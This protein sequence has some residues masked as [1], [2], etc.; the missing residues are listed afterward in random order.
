MGLRFPSL[1]DSAEEIISYQKNV[2]TKFGS[3]RNVQVTEWENYRLYPVHQ[4]LDGGASDDPLNEPFAEPMADSGVAGMPLSQLNRIAPI[5]DGE[6]ARL[7]SSASSPEITPNDKTTRIHRA[8]RLSQHVLE[9]ILD[10]CNWIEIRQQDR[11]NALQY[12]TGII[13]TGIELDFDDLENIPGDVYSCECGWVVAAK[14][15]KEVGEGI[16]EFS[17]ERAEEMAMNGIG[18]VVSPPGDPKVFTRLSACPECS[19]PLKKRVSTEADEGVDAFGD[20]L[21]DEIPNQKAF[22]RCYSVYDFFPAG[23]GRSKHG[24]IPEYTM[25]SIVDIESLIKRHKHADKIKPKT[26]SELAETVRWH[27]S[28][29]EFGGLYGANAWTNGER[30]RWCVYRITVREPFKNDDGEPEPLGRVIIS[31]NDVVLFNGPLMIEHKETKRKIPRYKIHIG[32][33]STEN[34]SCYGAGL[35]QRLIGMQDTVNN[36]ASMMEYNMH[37]FGSPRMHLPPGTTIEYIGTGAGKSQSDVLQWTGEQPP[38]VIQGN[39]QHP[40]ATKLIDLNFTSMERAANQAD[41][42]RGAPPPG[43]SAASAMIY[44]GDQAGAAKK[45][46]EERFADRDAKI[47]RHILEIVNA[48]YDTPRQLK[49]GDKGDSRTQKTYT[50]KDLFWQLDVKVAV[51]PSY[52]VE[53]YNREVAK[54]LQIAQLLPMVTPLEK[55]QS[56]MLLG[57]N[58]DVNPSAFR[59]KKIAENEWLDFMFGDPSVAPVVKTRYD[60]HAIHEFQ[61]MDDLESADGESLYRWMSLVQ[62]ATEGWDKQLATLEEAQAMAD[63]TPPP[64]VV[65]NPIS[66]QTDPIATQASAEAWAFG[67]KA[68]EI[69]DSMPKNNEQRIFQIMVKMLVGY[70]KFLTLDDESAKDVVML[71]RFLAHIEAHRSESAK[72][73][74]AAMVASMPPQ[75]SPAG[76][77][78]TPG[79][80]PAAN[81]KNPYN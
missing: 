41:I 60:D 3:V 43:V 12:G 40:D 6:V 18:S 65:K 11:R 68:R 8:A 80:I 47:M 35:V 27:P 62:L 4:W 32:R 56:A 59:Q 77:T 39:G 9:D 73:Q 15:G 2:T 28:G 7:I 71:V 16:L 31:A 76:P 67:I 51:K 49:A 1:D 20:S 37:T 14:S 53:V 38:E 78:P 63:G 52:N 46:T 25:E 26:L 72:A 44:L 70:P 29:V 79:Q 45:P 75:P 66:G 23:N 74:A 17:G 69:V 22:V 21:F 57:A 42:S 5:L 50:S 36:A 48:L 30:A 24:F 81:P 54:E 34:D 55:F 61:H 58:E 64:Q 13:M 10:E 19:M 33:F